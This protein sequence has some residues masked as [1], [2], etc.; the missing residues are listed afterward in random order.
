MYMEIRYKMNW[1]RLSY[2][3]VRIFCLIVAEF[4][5]KWGISKGILPANTPTPEPTS[6]GKAP[7]SA[8]ITLS[9]HPDYK[10]AILADIKKFGADAKVRGFEHIKAIHIDPVP[11]GI[12][13][14][15][16]TP[17]FK[18]KRVEVLKKY[19]AQIDGLYADISK[20]PT[21]SKL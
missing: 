5:V 12:E 10:S 1:L 14:G 13:D 19:R 6:P 15:L 9:S 20:L 11:F 16:L 21:V 8:I 4:G 17:T 18:L 3:T 7:C 2:Q